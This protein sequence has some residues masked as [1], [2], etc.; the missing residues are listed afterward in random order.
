M[1]CRPRGRE[2]LLITQHDHSRLSGE[3]AKRIGNTLFAA[4]SPFESV[5]RA[6]ADHDCGWAEAD[7]SP[8]IDPAG[9]PTHVF[10]AD[11]MISLAAW[12]QSVNQVLPHDPYAAL[13][14][15]LH[16]MALATRAAARQPEPE[17]E[18]ARQR[19]F[20]VRRFVH[21]QIEIQ[22]HLRRKLEMPTDL[23]LRGGLAEQGR[24]ATEDLLRANFFLLEFL[25]ELSL[26]LCFGRLVFQRIEMIYSR[27]DQQPF[28]A[29]IANSPDGAMTVNPWPFNSPRLELDVPARRIAPG[30]Y[31]ELNKLHAA[32]QAAEPCPLRVVL[33]PSGR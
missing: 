15:S 25:D 6:I 18:F 17:D 13:L 8:T 24:D 9:Q 29:F 27:P 7:A 3:L 19:V 4:P 2:L 1:I 12:E 11:I 28:S 21:Q 30:P 20:R 5:V 22:E 14:I 10:E 31:R 26:N 23:P 33:L 32:C 16:T